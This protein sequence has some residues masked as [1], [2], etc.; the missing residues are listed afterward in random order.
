MANTMEPDP[1]QEEYER[2]KAAGF[3]KQPS[4]ARSVRPAGPAAQ[5]QRRSGT[6]MWA[7]FLFVLS[8]ISIIVLIV[9][10]VIKVSGISAAQAN[11]ICTSALGQLGQGLSSA[12]GDAQPA[13]YCSEAAT[14]EDLKGLAAWAMVFFLIGGLLALARSSALLPSR[15]AA[16]GIGQIPP[17]R[18]QAPVTPETKLAQ[19]ARAEA[20]ASRLR[21]QAAQM[22]AAAGLPPQAVPG[23]GARGGSIT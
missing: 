2:Q 7:P 15:K 6:N 3:P 11:G 14:V 5:V 9:L 21:E 13:T 22:R 1:Y 19:A 4:Q 12:F 23:D 10:N 16:A 17:H 20:E 8:G 18:V